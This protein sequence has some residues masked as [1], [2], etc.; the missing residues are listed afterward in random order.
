MDI[1]RAAVISLITFLIGGVLGGAYAFATHDDQK[2]LAMNIEQAHDDWEVEQFINEQ[3]KQRPNG[4][5]ESRIETGSKYTGITYNAP[6]KTE[7]P[8]QPA[9]P[10]EQQA[11]QN[12]EPQEKKSGIGAKL[13]GI[14]SKKQKD[15][16][17]QEIAEP[18]Q[19]SIGRINIQSGSLNVRAQ[20]SSD[21]AVIGQV[22]RDDTVTIL[23]QDGAWYHIT[24]AN[25]LDGYVSAAYVDVLSAE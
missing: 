13:A 5:E 12:A 17:Q 21:G 3:E 4:L 1:K 24:T 7:E 14:F 18:E 23:S 6:A 19:S 20:G 22:Y 2:S 9:E 15:V 16:P 11:I 10:V 25:G 8:E